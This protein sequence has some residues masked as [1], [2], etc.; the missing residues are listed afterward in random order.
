VGR[1]SKMKEEQAE[2]EQEENERNC[3]FSFVFFSLPHVT[4]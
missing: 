2:Q 4:F 3:E 1:A